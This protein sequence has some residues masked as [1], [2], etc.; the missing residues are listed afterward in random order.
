M[1]LFQKATAV[2]FSATGT[3]RR[4][5]EAIAAALCGAWESIDLT[6]FDA[7]PAR[8]CF[9]ADEVVVFGAPVYGGRIYRGAAERFRRLKGDGTPCIVTVTYGNRDFDDA[10]LELADLV[11]EQGFCPVAAAALVGEHTYGEIQKG[12]PN[13]AD[14]AEDAAFAEKAAQKLAAGG[15][16]APDIPG[17]R[18]Y[19]EGGNGGKF[20]PRTAE[21]CTG[22]GLCA[23]ECPEGAIRPENGFAVNP[24]RCISCLRC[25]RRCPAGAKR[26]DDPAYLEF[27][28][29]FTRRLA[30][31]RENRYFL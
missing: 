27:A 20:F 13:A 4:G 1:K 14:L 19:R 21:S 22:C 8:T 18:P 10:L 5:A 3:S 17:N 24:Q 15:H 11:R 26:M 28:A 12:R 23:R 29:A 25:V 2:Y 9:G 16:S 31:R 7:V 6:R 30:A